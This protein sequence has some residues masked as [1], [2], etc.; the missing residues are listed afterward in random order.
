MTPTQLS[1]AQKKSDKQTNT[2]TKQKKIIERQMSC[3]AG[4]SYMN[5]DSDII[6]KCGIMKFN[7]EENKSNN[8]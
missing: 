1:T 7:S 6:I 2:Y 8:L 5:K 4:S 3:E